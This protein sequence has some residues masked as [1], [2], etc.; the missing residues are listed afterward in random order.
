MKLKFKILLIFVFITGTAVI[1][2]SLLGYSYSKSLVS[3]GIKKEMQTKAEG[4]VYQIEGWL[5]DKTT[6]LDTY[7][8]TIKNLNGHE[9]KN[10]AYFRAAQS[11]EDIAS[12]YMGFPDG[13]YFNEDGYYLDKAYDPRKKDWY[14]QACEQDKII[15]TKP[16]SD[17]N[18]KR[19]VFTVARPIKDSSNQLLGVISEDIY[20]DAIIDT[21]NN[22]KLY[23]EGYAFLFDD[24]GAILTHPD[25]DKIG[26]NI[27]EIECYQNLTDNIFSNDSGIEDIMINNKKT[28]LIYQKL[29]TTGWILGITVPNKVIL[30][31]ISNLK[32]NF[33]LY[34]LIA[35]TLASILAIYFAFKISNP[36]T[37][38]TENA[39]RLA[40]GDLTVK[41][42]VVGK[43]EFA[44]LSANFNKI[45]ENLRALIYDINVNVEL[46]NSSSQL[47]STSTKE[48]SKATEDI[49]IN[50]SDFAK[51]TENELLEVQKGYQMVD[52]ISK[53]FAEI[54]TNIEKTVDLTQEVQEVLGKGVEAVNNQ[55][56]MMERNKKSTIKVRESIN[57]LTQNSKTIGQIL[58]VISN[59]AQQT[60][61]LALNAAIEAARAGEQG[62]GFAVVAE[63]IRKLAEQTSSSSVEIANLIK[64]T[65]ESTKIAVDEM[66]ANELAVNKQEIVLSESKDNFDKIIMVVEIIISQ[67]QVVAAKS[68]NVNGNTEVVKQVIAS[69][70]ST[71]D[72]NAKSTE[73]VAAATEEHT[74]S[75]QEISKKAKEL[76]IV[77]E[78][79][80]GKI[81]NFKI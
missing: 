58:E 81:R 63:E 75:V 54:S 20:L 57:I 16:Y 18:T 46:L 15:F 8:A 13:R 11:H 50:I 27:S 48:A 2:V 31:Q 43:D 47:M 52:N 45:G 51:E 5:S 68:Q 23:E 72:R 17:W 79:L 60:N 64:E 67:I 66:K 74:A 30:G 49:A 59:I 35:I 70:A 76:A 55:F 77:S 69:V 44:V 62:K 9:I 38:L 26:K 71:A 73:R 40:D 3:Q 12:I 65:Q 37:N 53:A 32:T 14:I 36:L 39:K 61:L 33:I 24:S 80:N 4:V 56:T 10:T 25:K 19:M 6:L 28:I 29:P 78:N 21:V 42:D 34:I 22:L 1:G 41:V 7:K